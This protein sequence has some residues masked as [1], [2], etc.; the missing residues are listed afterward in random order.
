LAEDLRR[1][2]G[3]PTHSVLQR[4]LKPVLGAEPALFRRVHQKQ[5]AG[6]P[7]SL[8][9]KALFAF[10]LDHNDAFAGVGNSGCG[11][12]PGQSPPTTIT[13]ASSVIAASPGASGVE[14]RDASRGQRQTVSGVMQSRLARGRSRSRINLFQFGTFQRKGAAGKQHLI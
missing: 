2:R 8:T 3:R 13:S 6:R 7:E 14:A 1:D 10:L 5:S 4:Q 11:N 12:Q 9:A